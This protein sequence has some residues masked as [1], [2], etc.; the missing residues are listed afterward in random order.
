MSRTSSDLPG[1]TD[2]S[3]PRVLSIA[4][5]DPTG[6]AGVQADLKSIAANGGY[7]MA[8]VTA[9]VAQ[10]T[11][12]VRSIHRPPVDFLAEQLDAVSDDVTIDAVKIGML[13]DAEVV[14]VVTRWLDR[15]RPPVVVLD[16]V[17]V[18]AGGDRLL[19]V[20]AEAAVRDL[21]SHVHLVTPNIPELA[22]LAQ[23]PV[24]TTWDGVLGQARRVAAKHGVLVLAKG[25]HL[26]GDTAPDALVGPDPDAAPLVELTAPRVATRNTHG[27]GCS[28]SSALAT[29]RVRHG[30]W[31]PA[32]T[33][34]KRWLTSAIA[35]ADELRVGTG[36]G[37]IS[38]FADV[39]PG[40]PA[41]IASAWWDG[42]A[43]TRAAIDDLPFVR[44]L[45]DG[46]LAEPEFRWYL[47]QDALYLRDYSRALAAASALAPT[48]AEQAFWAGSARTAVVTELE[49][50]ASWIGDG[51]FAA[52]PGPACTAYLDHVLAA[53]AR[54]DYGV[55][56]ASLLP[57][58][59]IYEDVGARLLAHARPGHP[60]ERWLRT[61]GDEGFAD[62]TRQAVTIV[63][64]HAA[65]ATPAV[66]ARMEAAFRTSADHERAF[67]AAPTGQGRP[68]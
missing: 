22:V 38:H 63:T 35:H 8:V 56:V 14:D 33:A 43:A 67:F 48:P 19:G 36:N 32:L 9:L 11:H 17:M 13:F 3:A 47:A 1:S 65:T 15:V 7:G 41:R 10:N 23:E 59:W 42:I 29:L 18:A 53:V 66:R 31:A 57:C 62:V 68:G 52:E 64:G 55:L 37:P 61:Y 5:T 16:P 46:T 39:W 12:G 26:T 54:G 40:S 50:H 44:S 4:G 30:D 21:L 20:D 24:A 25:G 45:A 49:L 51:V 6:G 58:Y 34:A 27:T 2:G 60:Y 28:L